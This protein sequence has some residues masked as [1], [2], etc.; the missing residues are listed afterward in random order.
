MIGTIMAWPGGVSDIPDGWIICDGSA[1]DG[2]DFPLLVQAIQNSYDTEGDYG[3]T[4]SFPNYGGQFVLPNLLAGRF[5]ADIETEH[6]SPKNAP[7]TDATT[8]ITTITGG[9]GGTQDID[10]DAAALVSGLIGANTEQN[11]QEV[12]TDVFTDVEFTLNDRG[13]YTGV[14]SGNTI[15]PGI[16]EKSLFV[17]GRKL[18]H[19]HVASHTHPGSYETIGELTPT[20]PGLGVIP[21]D[22]IKIVYR[23]G[24]WDA[25]SDIED[26]PAI[27]GIMVDMF[28]EGPS[29]SKLYDGNN[30]AQFGNNSG[31]IGGNGVQAV[32]ETQ[33]ENPPINL[34]AKG[35]L[36]TSIANLSNYSQQQLTS[37]MTVNFA[38]AGNSFQIPAGYRNH[39]LD[40][41]GNNYGTLISN[42]AAAD[43]LD[44]QFF[45]HAHD[46]ITVVYQQGSLSPLNRLNAIASI[47]LETELDNAANVGA[48][49]INMNTSQPSVTSIYIIRAY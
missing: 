40:Y 23:Y 20:Q 43:W 36:R 13:G 26:D 14:I 47:P 21:Y 7:S 15:I 48:F 18:G 31:F 8:G 24:S 29:G 5:L 42:Q 6:F 16:G 32:M 1:K 39:Y 27:D 4:G 25:T 44:N 22:D 45:P 33:G 3:I 17:G 37:E 35:V 9:K 28:W 49:Q 34:S 30:W 19:Q 12:F 2:K 10:P 46:P 41:G 38:I 11:L